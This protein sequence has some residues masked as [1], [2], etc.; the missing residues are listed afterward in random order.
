MSKYNYYR[1]SDGAEVDESEACDGTVLKDGYSM[2][3][4]MRLFDSASYKRADAES[5][6]RGSVPEVATGENTVR[7]RHQLMD[8]LYAERDR[9]LSEMWRIGK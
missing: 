1:R 8:R 5:G 3:V 6:P 4:P 7:D 9:E 2:R